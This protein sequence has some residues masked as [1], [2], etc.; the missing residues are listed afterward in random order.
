M[1]N[2]GGLSG[3]SPKRKEQWEAKIGLIAKEVRFIIHLLKYLTQELLLLMSLPLLQIPDVPFHIFAATGDDDFR[4]PRPGMWSNLINALYSKENVVFGT[5]IVV[6]SIPLFP[7][8]VSFASVWL[9][10]PTSL[11]NEAGRYQFQ[12]YSTACACL[13]TRG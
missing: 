1:S 3:N 12:S 11:P 4:K 8:I 5:A 6:C 2:Q 13:L 7:P 10:N 9:C